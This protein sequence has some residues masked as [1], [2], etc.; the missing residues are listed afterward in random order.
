MGHIAKMCRPTKEDESSEKNNRDT[1]YVE[2]E[3]PSKSESIESELDLFVV[4][5]IQGGTD[6]AIYV[7]LKVNETPLCMELDTDTDVT[8][9]SEKVWKEQLS[10][11]PLCNTEVQLWTYTGEPLKVKGEVQ[12]TAAHNDQ[13]EKLPLLVVQGDRPSLFGKNW[14]RELRLNWSEIRK[15][16]TELEGLLSKYS[17]LFQ[18]GLGTVKDYKVKLAVKPV[19][20]ALKEAVEKDLERLELLGGRD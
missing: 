2:E 19:P 18:D 7:D 14:L 1:Q 13:M 6:N 4:K 11:V 15:V 12:V 10:A 5:S 16:T 17:G 3:R 9:I 8:L 20:F